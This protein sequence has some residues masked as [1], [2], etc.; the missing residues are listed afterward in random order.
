MGEVSLTI[1]GVKHKTV[2]KLEYAGLVVVVVIQRK[3]VRK[4]DTH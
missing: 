3:E 4:R 2:V 1:E